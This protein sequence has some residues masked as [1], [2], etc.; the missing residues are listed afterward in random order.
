MI[1][2]ER[3]DN[4]T[5]SGSEEQIIDY[6]YN[7]LDILPQYWKEYRPLLLTEEPVL[8]NFLFK[9]CKEVLHL[10]MILFEHKGSSCTYLF[11]LS[12]LYLASISIYNEWRYCLKSCF[13]R[14][15]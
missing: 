12:F 5:Y 11:H 14:I 3:I 8:L 15:G 10:E 4:L 1:S 13:I 6:L 7:Q 9:N 2:F